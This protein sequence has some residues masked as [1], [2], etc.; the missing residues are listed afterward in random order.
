MSPIRG[1][2][3]DWTSNPPC[4]ESWDFTERVKNHIWEWEGWREHRADSDMLEHVWRYFALHASQRI[5]LF[6]FFLLVAGSMSAGLAACIQRSGVFDLFGAGLGF[7]ISTV[8]FVFWK[9]DQRTRFLVKLAED[10]IMEIERALPLSHARIV[11]RE[12][13]RTAARE[14]EQFPAQNVDVWA[15]L[16][17]DVLGDGNRGRHR[18]SSLCVF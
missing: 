1:E 10:S 9:L 15:N 3:V 7:L 14:S 13:V 8:A 12:P 2:F 6:N 18:R 5:S 4:I 16:S 17:A 11:S